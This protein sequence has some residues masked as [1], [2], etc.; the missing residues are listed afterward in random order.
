MA[1]FA[2]KRGNLLCGGSIYLGITGI[3]EVEN[4][5]A[6]A[7]GK[8]AKG[9]HIPMC[10]EKSP[11]LRLFPAPAAAQGL[12]TQNHAILAKLNRRRHKRKRI[13][14]IVHR[15]VTPQIQPCVG[16]FKFVMPLHKTPGD[17]P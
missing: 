5:T 14:R 4:E 13:A 17:F 11:D 6:E 8:A 12:Q 3:T 1:Q 10:L 15:G 7:A 16:F 9:E 2:Q